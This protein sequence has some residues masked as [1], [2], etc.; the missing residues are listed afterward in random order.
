MHILIYTF[1]RKLNATL[2]L[3]CLILIPDFL[4][5]IYFILFFVGALE[6]YH[7]FFVHKR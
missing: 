6:N 5:Y 3:K 2:K 7:L 4:H 1:C